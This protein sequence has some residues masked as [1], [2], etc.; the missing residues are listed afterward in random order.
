VHCRWWCDLEEARYGLKKYK[1]GTKKRCT[2]WWVA[3]LKARKYTGWSSFLRTGQE[4]VYTKKEIKSGNGGLVLNQPN[5]TPA[6]A[7]RAVAIAHQK[8]LKTIGRQTI[9]K[10]GLNE[11]G[12]KSLK[13]RQAWIRRAS[14]P[15]AKKTLKSPPT[16][17]IK[18][19]Q[20]QKR[21]YPQNAQ[22]N[23]HT[24]GVRL[25]ID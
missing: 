16:F 11:S 14:V 6:S 13:A 4:G 21:T 20:S 5:L 19:K 22:G 1:E 8:E 24:T 23:S 17:T 25:R 7:K 15:V 10:K 9:G 18:R 3:L 2:V 12:E